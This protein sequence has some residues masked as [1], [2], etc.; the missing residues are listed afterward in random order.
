MMKPLLSGRRPPNLH[1]R[2]K[3]PDS[4][5]FSITAVTNQPNQ[6]IGSGKP[7][8]T[9]TWNQYHCISVVTYNIKEELLYPMW[10]STKINIYTAL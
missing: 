5:V 10:C 3:T 9:I 2:V 8:N 7:I 1:T 4:T 6:W